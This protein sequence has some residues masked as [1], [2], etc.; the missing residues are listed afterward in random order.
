MTIFSNTGYEISISVFYTCVDIKSE[1][2][3][4]VF[5]VPSMNEFRKQKTG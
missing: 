3:T 1:L 2:I 4:F 5:I